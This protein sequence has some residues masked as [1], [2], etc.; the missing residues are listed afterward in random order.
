[1]EYTNNL[2]MSNRIIN[3]RTEFY[4][5]EHFLSNVM[6]YTT[7]YG[8]GPLGLLSLVNGTGAGVS[9]IAG[10]AT[11]PGIVRL[12]LGTSGGS[13]A[14]GS[15]YSS[16]FS[17]YYHT[18]VGGGIWKA[19]YLIKPQSAGNPL[20]QVG[21][22]YDVYWGSQKIIFEN[23]GTL[24]PSYWYSITQNNISAEIHNSGVLTTATWIRLT[25]VINAAG[26]IVKFY[27][28]GALVATHTIYIPTVSL[29]TTVSINRDLSSDT[30][31]N[32]CDIDYTSL[33]FKPTTQIS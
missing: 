9:S 21:L 19:E 8:Y 26:N 6:P 25:I 20:Y 1:M 31:N 27:I 30:T 10:D 2:I 22:S 18:I 28:N 33:Y 17:G 3:P 16:I 4:A 7:S 13:G 5:I 11:H 14:P 15:V 23:G 24:S 32:F 29:L 12:N